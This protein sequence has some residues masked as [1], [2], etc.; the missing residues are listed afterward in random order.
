[1]LGF[2]LEYGRVSIDVLR[3]KRYM[4]STSGMI[5]MKE[6]DSD[7]S[8]SS[9]S[10]SSSSSHG[11]PGCLEG[12]RIEPR[13]D[14]SG[15]VPLLKPSLIFRLCSVVVMILHMNVFECALF[16]VAH[17]VGVRSQGFASCGSMWGL[18]CIHS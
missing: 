10:S 12:Q 1:M 8:H 5:G 18:Q 6:R 3:L 2:G 13:L 7:G 15:P 16:P 9:S 17:M 4:T 14:D 11:G